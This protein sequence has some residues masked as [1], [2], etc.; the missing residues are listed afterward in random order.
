MGLLYFFASEFFLLLFLQ[1][2]INQQQGGVMSQLVLVV[3]N[4]SIFNDV[5]DMREMLV[6]LIVHAIAT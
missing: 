2:K 6:P 5:E 4:H 1:S 3:L